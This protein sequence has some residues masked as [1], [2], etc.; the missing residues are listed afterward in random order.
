MLLDLKKIKKVDGDHF[1]NK[2]GEKMNH[3]PLLQSWSP[4]DVFSS[5]DAFHIDSSALKRVED[6]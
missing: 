4:D 5:S 3:V 1:Q 6:G 2:L